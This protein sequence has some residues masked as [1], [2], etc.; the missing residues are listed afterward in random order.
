[1]RKTIT[2]EDF[3]NQETD[4]AKKLR[5]KSRVSK[6]YSQNKPASITCATKFNQN[7]PILFLQKFLRDDLR[8]KGIGGAITE[9][10][11]N[12]RLFL[13]VQAHGDLIPHIKEVVAKRF[14]IISSEEGQSKSSLTISIRFKTKCQN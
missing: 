2:L 9:S 4:V 3:E 8:G 13:Y 7:L 6:T 14:D 10:R 11:G 12:Y 5:I 1:M